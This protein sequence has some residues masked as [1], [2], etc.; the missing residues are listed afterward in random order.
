MAG[1]LG[2]HKRR[3]DF[4][5]YITHNGDLDY[6]EELDTKVLRTH[7]EVGLWLQLVL[8]APRSDI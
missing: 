6:L 3:E 5:I 7:K 1:G 4:E 8:R 2:W